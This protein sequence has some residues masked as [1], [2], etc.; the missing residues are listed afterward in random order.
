[1]TLFTE[2][3]L[4]SA[5]LGVCTMTHLAILLISI[6]ELNKSRYTIGNSS[7]IAHFG[8]TI[9]VSLISVILAHTVQV[10]LWALSFLLLQT[11]P[12]LEVAVYFALATY[13][14]VGY[15]DVIA[16]ESWRVFAA[17]ASVTGL[18]NFGLSTAFLVR[19]FAKILP[20]EYS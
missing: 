15:G 10:W 1:M 8:K 16:Q 19:V 17:M 6:R 13:T 9:S 11:L 4:G 20:D 3:L 14:T 12:T 7:F 5:L 18:L 2:I